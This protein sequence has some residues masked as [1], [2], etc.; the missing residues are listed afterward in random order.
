MSLWGWPRSTYYYGTKRRGVRRIKD[1]A[2]LLSMSSLFSCRSPP[3]LR[4]PFIKEHFSLRSLPS[5]HSLIDPS[6]LIAIKM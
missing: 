4:G 5:P 6:I 1:M 2:I 3:S